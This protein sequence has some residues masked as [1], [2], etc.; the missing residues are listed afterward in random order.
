MTHA[1]QEAAASAE[2]GRILI[3]RGGALGDL[4]LTF[5]LFQALRGAWPNAWL[6]LAAYSP[7]GQLAVASGL[8]NR[9]K[10]LDDAA[11]AGRFSAEADLAVE[12]VEWLRSF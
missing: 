11:F 12:Q 5:P 8:V 10:S 6:E 3:L 4:I 9:L 1:R 7:Q 2:A